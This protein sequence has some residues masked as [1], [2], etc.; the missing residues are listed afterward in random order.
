MPHLK[1]SDLPFATLLSRFA[2]RVH[3]AIP[4]A[5]I[6]MRTADQVLAQR[7]GFFQSESVVFVAVLVSCTASV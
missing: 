3:C 2:L 1:F 4:N 7:C 6:V 5:A